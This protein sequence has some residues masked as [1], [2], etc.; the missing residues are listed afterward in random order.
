MSK[1]NDKELVLDTIEMLAQKR[2]VR[3]TILHSNQGFQYTSH[4]YKKRRNHRSS[5]EYRWLR[6]LF[7]TVYLTGI[8]PLI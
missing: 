2:D 3:G 8:R 1:R 4:A 5:I 7:N 6:S